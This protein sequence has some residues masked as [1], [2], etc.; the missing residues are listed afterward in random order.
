M[1][2]GKGLAG[3]LLKDGIISQDEVEVVEYGLENLGS[4]LLGMS[5]TLMLGYCF[6]FLLGSFMLWLFVFPLRKNAGGYHAETKARCL[7]FSS[8]I[9]LLSIICFRQI[10]WSE[11]VYI[12]V[13]AFS[14]LIVFIMAPIG[15]DNKHLDQMECK[16]YRRRTRIILSLEMGLFVAALLFGWEMLI[17]VVAM[18]FSIVGVSLVAG[19]IKLQI[20][21]QVVSGT[22]NMA[23]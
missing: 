5:V 15:N 8:A 3:K 23:E 14:F 22:G 18:A 7:L 11:T 6:D 1:R 9:L 19:R 20:H 10:K 21:K 13:T 4:S 17:A 2:V 16:V 12:W